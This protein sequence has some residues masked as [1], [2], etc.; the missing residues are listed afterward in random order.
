MTTYIDTSAL[1]AIEFGQDGYR[2]VLD[3]IGE[4][5]DLIASNLVEAEI[6]SATARERRNFNRSLTA[7]IT[8]IYPDRPLTLEFEL[9]LSAGY[10]RGADLWH[11]AVALYAAPDPSQISFI[12]LDTRQRDVAQ[13]IGFQT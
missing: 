7:N 4:A 2:N 13:G 12:T 9:I 3:R 8:W 5:S 1:L 6:Q 11:V 10:L